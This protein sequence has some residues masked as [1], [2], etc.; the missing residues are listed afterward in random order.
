MD[1][2]LNTHIHS[3]HTHIHTVPT[4]RTNRH[5]EREQK[6]VRFPGACVDPGLHRERH[7]VQQ[8]RVGPPEHFSTRP[9]FPRCTANNS[10]K[11]TDLRSFHDS[12]PIERCGSRF[13]CQH[14]IK[15]KGNRLKL[16]ARGDNR[17][18]RLKLFSSQIPWWWHTHY[19]VYSA[20]LLSY[21]ASSSRPDWLI[22]LGLSNHWLIW[23]AVC[24]RYQT[25]L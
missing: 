17:K 9:S 5:Q 18:Q 20:S 14:E 2:E 11:Y 19:S 15:L 3:T 21:S 23:R 16:K 25:L 6:T 13:R 7:T 4:V 1:D 24:G 22:K 8:E 10:R 12:Y